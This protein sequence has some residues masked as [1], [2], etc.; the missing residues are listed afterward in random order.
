MSQKLELIKNYIANKEIDCI[1]NFKNEGTYY[2]YQ[3]VG[4]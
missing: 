3:N 4:N 2:N 1:E